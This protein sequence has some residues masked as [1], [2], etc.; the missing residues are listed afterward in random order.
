MTGGTELGLTLVTPHFVLPGHV[1][2]QV[3]GQGSGVRGQHSQTMLT[4]PGM[5][6]MV[7]NGGKWVIPQD[8]HPEKRPK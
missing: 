8:C 5:S 2:S 7:P 3:M 4:P 6:E 1:V